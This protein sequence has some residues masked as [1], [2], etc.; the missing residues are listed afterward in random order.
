M[1]G[2]LCLFVSSYF[3]VF[4]K[5]GLGVIYLRLVHLR[6]VFHKRVFSVLRSLLWPSMALL[7]FSQVVSIVHSMWTTFPFPSHLHGY[8]QLN[9]SYNYQLIRFPVELLKADFS[10][11]PT[12]PPEPWS[13]SCKSMYFMRSDNSLSC[14][15]F[16]QSSYMAASFLFHQSGLSKSLFFPLSFDSHFMGCR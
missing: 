9:R 11:L 6:R 8:C 1:S 10:C 5:F 14:I 12:R 13:V 4:Y 15:H 3:V 7:M 16:W 2:S